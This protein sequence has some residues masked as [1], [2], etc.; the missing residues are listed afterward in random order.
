MENWLAII[1][2]RIHL[3]CPLRTAKKMIYQLERSETLSLGIEECWGF[4]S[5]PRNLEKITPPAL[6]FRVKGAL[7]EEIYPGLMIAYRVSPLL[8]MPIVWLTEIVQVRAPHFFADEQRIGPYRLWH[9][10]HFFRALPGG[11]TEVRDLVT[12]VPP[13]GPFGG[14]LNR[15]LI[16][17][18]LERIFDYRAAQLPGK[19]S[20]SMA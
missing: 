12:Y 17:P 19:G 8:G 2:R 4:F 18:R 7:P 5:N 1:P 16:R 3:H 15:W 10:E 11:R 14:L 13:L 9:H 6:R 20:Q